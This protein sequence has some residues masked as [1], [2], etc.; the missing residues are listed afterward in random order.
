MILVFYMLYY[1]FK[2]RKFM[3]MHFVS[4]EHIYLINF[5]WLLFFFFNYMQYIWFWLILISLEFVPSGNILTTKIWIF[6][7]MKSSL[8]S[9]KLILNEFRWF[10]I[11]VEI[12]IPNINV[13]IFLWALNKLYLILFLIFIFFNMGYNI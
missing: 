10:F 2:R 7:I 3:I 4:I 5:L 13:F 9:L 8:C 6:C 12:Y 11:A 1:K